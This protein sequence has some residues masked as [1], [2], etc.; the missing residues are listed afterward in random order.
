VG[1][2]PLIDKWG[3]EPITNHSFNKWLK[4]W[5]AELK[6]T[7]REIAALH[8]RVDQVAKRMYKIESRLYELRGDE[9]DERRTTR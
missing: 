4:H 1:H 3:K 2:N 9:E 6:A 7:H 8:K 5:S